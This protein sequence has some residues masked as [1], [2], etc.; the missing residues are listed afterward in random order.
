MARYRVGSK[1]VIDVYG[2]SIEVT[3]TEVNFTYYVGVD[4]NGREWNF[5]NESDV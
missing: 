2:K 1:V 5:V 3:I 4:A